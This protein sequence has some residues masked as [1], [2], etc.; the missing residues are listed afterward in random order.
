[1]TTTGR[2]DYRALWD[3]LEERRNELGLSKTA[4]VRDIAWVSAGVIKN[5]EQGK[6]TTCQ[7]VTG[8]LRWLGRTPES[9][10]SGAHDDAACALPDVG[11]FALRWSMPKLWEAVDARRAELSLSWNDVAAEFQWPGVKTFGQDIGYGIPMDLAMR[12]T[13]WLGLPAATFM[14]AAEP[15][16]DGVVSRTWGTAP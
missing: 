2:F 7:H 5:L 3:A 4:M 10:V 8:L 13:Q 16:P 15:A 9:F 11:A 1:M 14:Y 12:I 6:G